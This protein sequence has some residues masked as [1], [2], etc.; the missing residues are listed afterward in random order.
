MFRLCGGLRETTAHHRHRFDSH[1][2]ITNMASSLSARIPGLHDPVAKVASIKRTNNEMRQRIAQLRSQLES[3]RAHTRQLHRDKVNEL[4]RQQDISEVGIASGFYLLFFL[5]LAGRRF[6]LPFCLFSLDFLFI[7]LHPC[8]TLPP[9]PFICGSYVADGEASPAGG[10]AD[11]A[12]PGTN[13]SSPQRTRAIAAREGTRNR[14]C[15]IHGLDAICTSGHV[16]H[17]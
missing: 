15:E 10:A 16:L 5:G 4:R 12:D 2:S 14:S 3:D 7:L 1:N 6:P 17:P 8:F 9:P 11:S 13:N